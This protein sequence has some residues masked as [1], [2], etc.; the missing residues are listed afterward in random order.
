MQKKATQLIARGHD[1]KTAGWLILK[2]YNVHGNYISLS[3][4][5]NILVI[6]IASFLR[7]LLICK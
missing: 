3:N 2:L 1:N 4:H 6:F 7:F 5:Y